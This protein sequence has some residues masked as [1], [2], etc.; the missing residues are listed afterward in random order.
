MP[1]EPRTSCA[2]TEITVRCLSSMRLAT[3]PDWQ[4]ILGGNIR[5]LRQQKG[6]TQEEL[7]FEAEIH[8]TSIGRIERGRRNP[9]LLVMARI[10][11]ALSVALP[12]LLDQ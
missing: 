1:G 12:K 9:S 4:A 10:A 5:R 8:L 3:T 2:G 6:L 11:D 7:A